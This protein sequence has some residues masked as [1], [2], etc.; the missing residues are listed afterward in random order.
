MPECGAAALIDGREVAIFR[1]RDATYAI[2]NHDPASGANVLSRGIVGDVGGEIVVASPLYKHHY[3]LVSG[4]CLEDAELSVPVYLSRIS[5]G[6]VWIRG[7][8]A[9]GRPRR[10]RRRLVVIG[11]GIAATHTLEALLELAPQA[12]D[13]TVFGAETRGGYNRVLLSNLLAGEKKEADIITHPPEWYRTRGIELHAGDAIESIDRRRRCVRSRRGLVA[14]Y[15]RL[16]IATGAVPLRLEV[17]G[18]NLRGIATL[19]NLEDVEALVAAAKTCRRAIVIGGGLLGLEAASGLKR[20]GM[21]VTV[22]HLEPELMDRQLDAQAAALLRL[23]L[24][25]RGLEFVMPARATGFVGETHVAGV[26]TAD[27]LVLPAELVVVAIGIRPNIVLAQ[28]AGLACDRGILVDDTLATHD[29]AIYAVG[30]CVQHRGATFGLVAPL[31]AQAQVCASFLAERAA[32]GYRPPEPSTQLK[33]SGIDV[34]SAGNLKPAPGSES[35][36]L[37]DA[38]RGIYKRLIIEN[39]RIRG[40]LLYGDVRDG[41]WYLELMRERRDI[42]ELRDALLFGAPRR[43]AELAS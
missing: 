14:A 3:S 26:K 8:P 29:P 27:G 17:P 30:E 12:H 39:D 21:E 36:V 19:R 7:N 24:E 5:S 16:L 15:D 4:R 32:R 10:A 1:V 35:L 18:C 34:F 41:H 11:D 6:Q 33:V 20:R 38:R 37:R 28:S 42:R 22:L 13:I 31:M 2:G 9:V 23:E 43:A 25:K 40:A